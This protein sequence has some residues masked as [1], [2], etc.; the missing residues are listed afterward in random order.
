MKPKQSLLLL[1][2]VLLIGLVS[3]SISKSS[4]ALAIS[5]T[6]E[7]TYLIQWIGDNSGA[8][9]QALRD[10]LIRKQSE[11]EIGEWV[12]ASIQEYHNPIQPLYYNNDQPLPES[13]RHEFWYHI[14]S[15]G[16]TDKSSEVLMTKDG[17]VLNEVLSMDGK[18]ILTQSGQTLEFV[19]Y[20]LSLNF[21]TDIS[22]DRQYD[23]PGTRMIELVEL[24]GEQV[25]LIT[26]ISDFEDPVLFGKDEGVQHKA[27][28][29]FAADNGLLLKSADIVT[30]MDGTDFVL[31]ENTY[32]IRL[33]AVP[34]ETLL[35]KFEMDPLR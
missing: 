26:T 3:S 27:L 19:P 13:V 6:E 35:I 10:E 32:D 17:K 4:S 31:S 16:L 2:S 24:T 23:I 1:L 34:D 21:G 15:D 14:N 20:K 7:S 12:Y 25:Y 11:N 8:D 30:R 5:P 33:D 18:T 22:A 9:S 29:Y 28:N